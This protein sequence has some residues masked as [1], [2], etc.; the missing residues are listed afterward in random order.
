MQWHTKQRTASDPA[1]IGRAIEA[2]YERVK[3]NAPTNRKPNA[4]AA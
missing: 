1:S 2:A 4:Q 3:A